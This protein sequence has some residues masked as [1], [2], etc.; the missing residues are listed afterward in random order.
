M[1]TCHTY[2]HV[3]QYVHQSHHVY[4]CYMY[5]GHNVCVLHV[6]QV[7]HMSATPLTLCVSRHS[8]PEAAM[9]QGQHLMVQGEVKH[10]TQIQL[11]LGFPLTLYWFIS[12]ASVL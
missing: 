2:V 10:A 11:V 4:V 5:T 1:Y 6:S 3:L 8:P 7:H 9:P 12:S